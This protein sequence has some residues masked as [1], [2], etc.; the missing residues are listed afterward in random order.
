MKTCTYC[1]KEKP[2]EQF[3]KNGGTK[4]KLACRCKECEKLI[5][6]KKNDPYADL[7]RIF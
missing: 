1:K 6:S 3:N 2:K 4:D 7:Y 5:K